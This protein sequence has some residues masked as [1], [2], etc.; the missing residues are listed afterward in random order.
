[1]KRSQEENFH[2][3]FKRKQAHWEHLFT[4]RMNGWTDGRPG[5]QGSV[6]MLWLGC[7]HLKGSSNASPLRLCGEAP[8]WQNQPL[9]SLA[10][11]QP[12]LSIFVLLAPAYQFPSSWARAPLSM[13]ACRFR[14][15]VTEILSRFTSRD[16][17][18]LWVRLE[19][20]RDR[21]SPGL[22][23]PTPLFLLQIL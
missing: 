19:T 21:S 8:V 12:L 16:S 14:L 18:H 10:A 22:V 17:P 11:W 5:W 2:W 4:C 15:P 13:E 3:Q 6:Q 23:A 20:L 1:M 9:H 7:A